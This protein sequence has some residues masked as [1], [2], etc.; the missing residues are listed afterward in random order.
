MHCVVS[1]ASWRQQPCRQLPVNC[2]HHLLV[3]IDQL[4]LTG[5]AAAIFCTARSLAMQDAATPSVRSLLCWPL[6]R[7]LKNVS[8]GGTLPANWSNGHPVLYEMYLHQNNLTG[9][10]VRSVP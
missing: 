10:L 5:L 3:S 4:K 9:T 8:I 6:R 1:L 7:G 2:C